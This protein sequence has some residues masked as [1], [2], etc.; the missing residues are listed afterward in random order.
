MMTASTAQ[1]VRE[2]RYLPDS[3]RDDEVAEIEAE[4]RDGLEFQHVL[5]SGSWRLPVL[6]NDT[7][8]VLVCGQGGSPSWTLDGLLPPECER[9]CAAL[10]A[11]DAHCPPLYPG[12]IQEQ[13]VVAA[14]ATL[15]HQRGVWLRDRVVLFLHGEVVL[16]GGRPFCR[17]YSRWFLRDAVDQDGWDS[18]AQYLG[19]LQSRLFGDAPGDV[20]V[21]SGDGLADTSVCMLSETISRATAIRIAGVDKGTM[22]RWC[23]NTPGLQVGRDISAMKFL[24][25]LASRPVR[26]KAAGTQSKDG[27]NAFT[28]PEETLHEVVSLYVLANKRTREEIIDHVRGILPRTSDSE[29]DRELRQS[30]VYRLTSH[31]GRTVYE[32]LD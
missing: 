25:K 22:S 32:L 7:M 17:P 29:I 6:P 20:S 1:W 21:H 8:Q 12:V 14:L 31:A 9:L 26:D 23:A 19:W 16:Y 28:D 13:C 10:D 18:V 24:Q 3:E 11:L 15:L 5:Y 4:I 27:G 30:D 2:H